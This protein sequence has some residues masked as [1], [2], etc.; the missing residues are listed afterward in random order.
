VIVVISG[1]HAT[2]CQRLGFNSDLDIS[3][4]LGF[5]VIWSPFVFHRLMALVVYSAHLQTANRYGTVFQSLLWISS[6][7]QAL[8]G[9]IIPAFLMSGLAA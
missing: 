9:S 1:L 7:L 8:V 5:L 4:S 3:P 2:P 6:E